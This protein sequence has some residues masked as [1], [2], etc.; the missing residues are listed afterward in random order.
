MHEVL[1]THSTIYIK[2]HFKLIIT[3]NILHN[4]SQIKQNYNVDTFSTYML[5][6]NI[7]GED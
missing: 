4:P 1:K 3:L 6:F 5:D 7:N 2:I